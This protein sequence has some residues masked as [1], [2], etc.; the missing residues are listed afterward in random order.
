MIETSLKLTPKVALLG[1]TK[2]VPYAVRCFVS[3]VLL[4][5][6]RRVS[7]ARGG[8]RAP[9]VRDWL[10]AFSYFNDQQELYYSMMLLTQCSRDIWAALQTYLLNQSKEQTAS[11]GDKV[12]MIHGPCWL[13]KQAKW[14]HANCTAGGGGAAVER[15]LVLSN[16]TG[17]G[18]GLEGSTL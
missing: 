4:L 13:V 15:A 10:R 3:V 16:P 17:E 11:V 7:S 18:D 2:E 9:I 6:K 5:A 8:S 14:T 1:H 12:R